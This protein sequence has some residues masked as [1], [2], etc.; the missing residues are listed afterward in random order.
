MIVYFLVTN[1][2]RCKELSDKLRKLQTWAARVVTF[3]N[4]N[5]HSSALLE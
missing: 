5:R 4:Y 2:R 1:S 3:S